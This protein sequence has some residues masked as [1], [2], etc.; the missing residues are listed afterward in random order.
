MLSKWHIYA[1]NI[2]VEVFIKIEK[3]N[4]TITKKI[5]N[6]I[7]QDFLF[8]LLIIWLLYIII[9][10]LNT[11][12]SIVLCTLQLFSNFTKMNSFLRNTKIVFFSHCDLDTA[13]E[14]LVLW[15]R[16]PTY[17]LTRIMHSNIIILYYITPS[18]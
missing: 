10:H 15:R 2:L 17:N 9:L 3:K 7:K 5:K 18:L 12:L 16:I 13:S 6:K 14:I 11:S 1:K 4:E 8:H